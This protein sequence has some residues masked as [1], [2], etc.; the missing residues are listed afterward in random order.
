MLHKAIINTGTRSAA[1]ARKPNIR[2]MPTASVRS[3]E[4]TKATLFAS[5]LI[6]FLCVSVTRP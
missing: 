5:W 4:Q 2:K 3:K 1:R 6:S